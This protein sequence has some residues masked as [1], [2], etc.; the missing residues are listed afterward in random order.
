MALIYLDAGH[1]GKDSG[2]AANGIKEKDIVLKLV[3]KMEA[4]LKNYED[5]DVMLSR[6]SDVFL[7][8]DERTK[9]ANLA[10]ADVLLSVHINAAF[11][12]SANGFE[13]YV[14]NTVPSST[15]AFQNVMHEEIMKALGKNIDDRGK[16]SANFHMVRDSKMKAVLTE[17]LFITNPTEADL[18][19][20]DD[21]LDKIA[22]G[23]VNGL[24]QFLGLKK[25]EKPPQETD[26]LYFVQ[27]GAF[28]NKEN[29]EVLA[30]QLKDDGYNS[31]IKYQ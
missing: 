6:D 21:F 4:M 12:K 19:K 9:E 5:V 31:Y 2:A 13:T 1:G 29:A 14:F 27:C 7:T 16:K 30:A 17:N 15:I 25:I 8:L 22:T 28:A 18:L 11:D 3:K 10:N 23:H 26:K 24:Q 20:D